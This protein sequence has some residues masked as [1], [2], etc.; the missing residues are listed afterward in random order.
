MFF[1]SI[2]L[3][4]SNLMPEI[5]S[6]YYKI[7]FTL[8]GF[9]FFWWP[10][11]MLLNWDKRTPA[12]L[13]KD[14]YIAMAATVIILVT[15]PCY[16]FDTPL[17]PTMGIAVFVGVIIP[18]MSVGRKRSKER[19]VEINPK[20]IYKIAISSPRA[21]EFLQYFPGAR[22]YVYG[23]TQADGD[24]AH[25]V[26]HHR[27][28]C[29]EVEAAQ[30]DYVLDISVDRNLSLY[31]SGKEQL[32]CYFFVNEEEKSNVGFLPSANIGRALDYGFTDHDY[33]RA[34]EEAGANEQRWSLIGEKPISIQHYPGQVVEIAR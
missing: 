12:S 10:I 29:A 20:E 1:M 13:A 27:T 8:L 28:P 18:T 22:C 30:I 23:L 11:D 4:V 9:I 16:W 24:R 17:W 3:Q 34:I 6:I 21:H 19:R 15:I 26:L 5:P 33:E 14:K 32:Q 31:I 7:Y 25:M 2:I